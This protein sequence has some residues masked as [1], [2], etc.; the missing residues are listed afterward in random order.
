MSM[1]D[2][3]ADMLTRIRNAAMAHKATVVIPASKLKKAVALLL[4]KHRFI[5][6][7]VIIEDDKQDVIKILLNYSEE[8]QSAIRGIERVSKPGRRVYTSSDSMPKVLNGLGFAFVSTSKGVMTGHE[9][10]KSNMGGEVI[11]KVW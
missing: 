1:S 3:I 6:K 10:R 2:P 5:K 7:F 8:G 11:C 4:Q 9:A